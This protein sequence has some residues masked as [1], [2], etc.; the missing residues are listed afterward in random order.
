MAIRTPTGLFAAIVLFAL[1][2]AGA[3]R[4]E[5]LT[6]R[7]EAMKVIDLSHPMYE[8]MPVW[9]GGVPFQMTRVADYSQGYRLHKFTMAENV[10]THVDAPSHYAEGARDI[11]DFTA[12]DLIV[13]AVVIDIRDRLATDVDYRLTVRDVRMWEEQ[14][15]PIP[16][17]SLVILNTGWH[18]WFADRQRYVNTDTDQT[19]HF[20][21][22]GLNSAR[23]LLARGVAGLGIDTLSID[24]GPSRDFPVHHLVLGADK[25]MIENL[26]NL[27][28]LP[29]RGATV[30][31][32]VLKV[33]GGSQAQAR[34][35]A[36]LP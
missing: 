35:F 24:H 8:G 1:G 27:G 20:P 9:P 23:L 36:L 14:Y 2:A 12:S 31:I 25:F 15:G 7:V 6:H 3:A 28:A 26:N 18:R 5:P 32:G 30:V 29:P 13:P 33:R 4:G 19:K 11:D 17:G 22:F 16:A 21:G 10:G 34:I